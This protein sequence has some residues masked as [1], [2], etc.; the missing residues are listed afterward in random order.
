MT[1]SDRIKELRRAAIT[2]HNDQYRDDLVAKGIRE[3]DPH[4]WIYAIMAFLDE[5]HA[6]FQSMSRLEGYDDAMLLSR[7]RT[8][9]TTATE[10]ILC[11]DT[12]PSQD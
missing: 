9:S 7:Y 4:Y 10:T 3:Q 5:Q 2:A 6:G 8:G 12:Q 11:P 1:P